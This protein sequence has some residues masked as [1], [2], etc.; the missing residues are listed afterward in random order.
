MQ[1]LLQITEREKSIEDA[2]C[3]KPETPR[4]I[5]SADLGEGTVIIDVKITQ[6]K[7]GLRLINE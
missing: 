6:V 3:R 2:F 5:K 4:I 1:D 7:E